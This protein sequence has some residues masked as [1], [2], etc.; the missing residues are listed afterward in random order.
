MK[1]EVDKLDDNKLVN[2]PISLNNFKKDDL[3][4][5]KLTTVPIDLKKLSNAVNSEVVKNIK[6]NTL[7][8]EV[9]KLDKSKLMMRLL[10]FSLINTTQINKIW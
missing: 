5:G 6:I 3:D 1:A 2:V 7:K 10:Q 9:N 8:A 4:V